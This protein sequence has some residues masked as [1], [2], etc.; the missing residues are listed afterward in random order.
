MLHRHRIVNACAHD[1]CTPAI[2]RAY[3]DAVYYS[4]WIK[5]RR[6]EPSTH[7]PPTLLRG[8]LQSVA[9]ATRRG[10]PGESQ[11]KALFTWL[12]NRST[13]SSFTEPLAEP[14]ASW[15]HGTYASALETR[16]T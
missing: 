16:T 3:A 14:R 6:G 11:L 12:D 7:N 9:S 15:H 4:S 8:A 5:H 10:K 1:T 2:V 13:T